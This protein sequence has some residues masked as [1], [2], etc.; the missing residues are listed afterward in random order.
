M[1]TTLLRLSGPVYL[2]VLLV[3]VP[4]LALWHGGWWIPAAFASLLVAVYVL[5]FQR[6][7][8]WAPIREYVRE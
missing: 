7:W 6:G 5:F 8:W 3:V 1:R 4:A 2:S